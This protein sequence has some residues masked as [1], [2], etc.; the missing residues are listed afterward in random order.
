MKAW[1]CMRVAAAVICAAGLALG[2]AGG[3]R[4]ELAKST[5]ISIKMVT[6]ENVHGLMAP[7]D[8][9]I[10]ICG[11]Y[12][13]IYHGVDNGTAWVWTK[14]E[15]GVNH[16]LVSGTFINDK[17]GWIAGQLGTILHT[18]DGGNTWV[19]QN[20]GTDKHLFNV[21]F[22]DG[23]NG[24]AV[25]DGNTILHTS[26]GGATWTRQAEE[27][28]KILNTIHCIDADTCWIVGELG[29]I[30]KTTNSGATWD[31]VMP[32][33][34]ERKTVEEEFENPRPALFAIAATDTN[35]V[36]LAGIDGTIIHTAD[37]GATWQ[38]LAVP[39]KEGIYSL[40]IRDGK[41]WAVGDKGTYLTSSDSGM[42]WQLVEDTIKTKQWLGG[43]HFTDTQKGWATGSGGTI[44][45]TTD[46]GAT[47]TFLSG[48]SYA[49][50]FFQMPKALEFRDMVFE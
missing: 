7:D 27:G 46:G 33:F 17:Q 18:S 45:R 1:R 31:T 8:K 23:R 14:Q 15:S 42:T 25:G 24:W 29:I 39:I 41:G 6:S 21:S 13:I 5:K 49:M 50:E 47:W 9:N 16:L 20:S 30:L 19:K 40:C 37:G 12:G 28:D 32:Q 2:C 34:F 26:D 11:G 35:H 48:L 22:V 44:V 36:W 3:E 38:Q 10:W 43:V 4:K